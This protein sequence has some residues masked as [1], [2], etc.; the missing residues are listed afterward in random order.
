VTVIRG[1]LSDIDDSMKR[2]GGPVDPRVRAVL[3]GLRGLGLPVGVATGKNAD[4]AIGLAEGFGMQWSYVCAESG[5]HFRELEADGPPPV[6]RVHEGTGAGL[7]DLV[8]FRDSICLDAL[9]RKF[10]LRRRMN[11]VPYMPELKDGILTLL[12]PDSDFAQTQAWAV[13]FEEVIRVHD[14]RL[15]VKR[16][17]AN[18]S[19]DIVPEGINKG[20]GVTAVCRILDCEPA[21]LLTIADGENDD[22]LVDGTTSVAVG[23]AIP[24][25]RELVRIRGGYLARGEN[26]L[27]LVE[28]VLHYAQLGRFGEHSGAIM[29]LIKSQ[30]P[31]NSIPGLAADA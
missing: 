10:S 17:K 2:H 5:A 3:L 15:V 13:F 21:E 26:A 22:E 9:H 24:R 27:G 14:L 8:Q 18:G 25:I 6:W 29:T 11:V 23:N 12:P 28:G 4:Y 20:L 31:D 30:F 1:V 7:E 19:I 16:H